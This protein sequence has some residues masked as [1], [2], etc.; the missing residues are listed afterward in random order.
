MILTVKSIEY[1]PAS[2]DHFLGS[3]VPASTNL[4]LVD[5]PLRY[6]LAAFLDTPYSA[7]GKNTAYIPRGQAMH[8]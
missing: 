4:F 1:L 6:S 7:D 3:F 2:C 8:L 5:Q